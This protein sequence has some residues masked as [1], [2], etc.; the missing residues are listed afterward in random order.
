MPLR[1]DTKSTALAKRDA[2]FIF[3]ILKSPDAEN[4]GLCKIRAEAD[5]VING[6]DLTKLR[7]RGSGAFFL[8]TAATW[9]EGVGATGRK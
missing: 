4:V 3:A 6:D 5:E 1:Y 9:R 8:S 7:I 2:L